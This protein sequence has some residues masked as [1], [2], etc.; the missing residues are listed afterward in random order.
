[1]DIVRRHHWKAAGLG[2]FD[3]VVVG[4]VVAGMSMVGEL[5]GD[6]ITAEEIDEP[7]EFVSA[8]TQTLPAASEDLPLTTGL[9]P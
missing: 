9:S 5:D 2:E 4:D 8:A 3:E 6:G 1:M 7:V